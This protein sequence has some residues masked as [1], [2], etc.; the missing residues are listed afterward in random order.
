LLAGV[1][2]MRQDSQNQRR[3]LA[4]PSGNTAPL[5]DVIAVPDFAF[6][7]LSR[8]RDSELN[9]FSAYVQDQLNIGGIVELVAGLRFERFDLETAE[10][11][12]NTP[13]DRVDEEVSPRFAAII[14]PVENLSI[15]ASYAESFLPQSG[16]QFFLLSPTDASF[17]PEKFENLELGAKYAIHPGLLL[18]AAL[19]RLERSNTRAPDPD[20]TGLVLLTGESRVEGFEIGLAGE[21]IPNLSVNLGYA[22]LDGKITETT[23]AAAAGT[24]LEQVPEH[25]ITAWARYD[26]TDRLGLGAGVVHMSSQFASLSNTVVLPSYTRVDAAIFFDV[27]EQLALQ[28]NVENLLDE[29][30]FPSAHGNNN[31]QPGEPLNASLGAR[32]RF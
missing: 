24:T 30:F 11:L 20:N 14:K 22:Y 7:P 23:S 27:T 1:E 5:A 32:L 28:L 31:I 17:E 8:D 19:F 2:V 25:H 18:T 4:F 26:L 3:N 9:V 12:T 16:D 29:D 10:L 13:V 21:V 6:L 15:Y